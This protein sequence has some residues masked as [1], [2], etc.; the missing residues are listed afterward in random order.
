MIGSTTL[1]DGFVAGSIHA[2]EPNCSLK[3]IEAMINQD[4]YHCRRGSNWTESEPFDGHS[5]EL[6]IQTIF[7]LILSDVI[8]LF[9]AKKS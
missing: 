5:P 9:Q 1:V 7:T 6:W 4:L 8:W 2:S 3:E